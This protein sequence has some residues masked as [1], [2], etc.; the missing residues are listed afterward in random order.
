MQVRGHV[1]EASPRMREGLTQESRAQVKDARD[2]CRAGAEGK[3]RWNRS[4]ESSEHPG[5]TAVDISNEAAP[6]FSETKHDRM[7]HYSW[8]QLAIHCLR[9]ALGDACWSGM[10]TPG[11][12]GQSPAA[13]RGWAADRKAELKKVAARRPDLLNGNDTNA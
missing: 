2:K 8:L 6:S 7:K 3:C 1:P 5:W 9:P 4:H 13:K 12:L 11:R 10:P